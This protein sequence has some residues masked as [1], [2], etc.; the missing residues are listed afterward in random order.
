MLVAVAG[1]VAVTVLLSTKAPPALADTCPTYNPPNALSLAG[2]TPQSAT[3]L[4]PFAQQLQATVLDTHDNPVGGVTVTFTAPSSGASAT[5]S[6]PSAVTDANGYVALRHVM[7]V[8]EKDRDFVAIAGRFLGVP[9]LWGGK[10]SLG[11][12]CSA[13]VQLALT[14]SGVRSPRDSDMQ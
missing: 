2:G 14:G 13:L 10:S 7:R 4:A 6:A 8:E 3:I 11:L 1:V 12:D 9:Y 5:L